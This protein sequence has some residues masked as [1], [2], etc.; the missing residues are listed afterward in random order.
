MNPYFEQMILSA[1]P[2]ELIRLLYQRAIGALRDARVSL[3]QG[4]VEQR[5]ASI[6][7]AYAV[8]TELAG[9]LRAEEA[10]EL[11]AKLEGLYGYMQTR[12]VDANFRQVEEPLTEVIGLLTIL[13]EAWSAVPD[14]LVAEA[15]AQSRWMPSGA[16]ARGSAIGDDGVIRVAV[17]A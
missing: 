14:P 4:R 12:L 17:S 2:V 10:P 6:N 15:A 7:I 8:L 13:A 9:S 3:R 5:S 1:S 11:A 16:S